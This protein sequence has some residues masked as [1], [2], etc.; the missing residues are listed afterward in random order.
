VCAACAW[1]EDPAVLLE[2]LQAAMKAGNWAEAKSLS[3]ELRMETAK[4]R[5]QSLA[6]ANAKFVDDVLGWLPPDTETLLVTERPFPM[7]EAGGESMAYAL[8]LLGVAEDQRL[9]KALAGR[10]MQSA[11]MAARRFQSHEPGDGGFLPLGLIAY[12]GCGFYSLAVDRTIFGQASAE[13]VMG[14][15]VWISHGY[16]GDPPTGSKAMPDTYFSLL[17]RANLLVVCNDRDFLTAVLTRMPGGIAGPRALPAALAEWKY[18]DRTRPF[19]EIRHFDNTRVDVDM[20]NPLNS[21]PSNS[22]EATGLVVEFDEKGAR[23]R[24]LAKG[25]PWKALSGAPDFQGGAEVHEVSKGVWE[26]RIGAGRQAQGMAVFMLM[27]Q[28]GF[29][30]LL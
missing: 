11:V 23:A 12:Q 21:D 3:A 28:L 30:V 4:R 10:T 16:Q 17:P 5:D 19:W 22:V 14:E 8:G 9:Y 27:G 6:G 7:V 24:M 25:N 18:V 15:E 26:L 29:A 13:R 20:T 1:A 2:R